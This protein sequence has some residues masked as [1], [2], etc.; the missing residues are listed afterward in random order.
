MTWTPSAETRLALLQEG[1]EKYLRGDYPNPR[2]HRPGKCEHGVYYWE[3][4]E[5]CNDAFLQSILDR[6]KQS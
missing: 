3:Q 2:D 4:C 6:S 5:T 1:L